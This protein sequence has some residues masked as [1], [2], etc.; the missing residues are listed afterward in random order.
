[1]LEAMMKDA[2]AKEGEGERRRGKLNAVEVRGEREGRRTREALA[3]V[4]AAVGRARAE[5]TKRSIQHE[6]GRKRSRKR[7]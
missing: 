1:M 4:A 7:S 6:S 2:R 5:R 3:E